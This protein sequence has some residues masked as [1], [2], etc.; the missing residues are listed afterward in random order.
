MATGASDYMAYFHE[1]HCLWP[2]KSPH[3]AIGFP[4]PPSAHTHTHTHTLNLSP[5]LFHL[6]P[7]PALCVVF[8]NHSVLDLF[9]SPIK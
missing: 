6:V 5:S 9:S 1:K 4:L 3:L 2:L 7:G 8:L